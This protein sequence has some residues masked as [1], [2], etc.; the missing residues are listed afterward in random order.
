I[1]HN[2]RPGSSTAL[3]EGHGGIVGIGTSTFLQQ[4][5]STVGTRLILLTAMLIGMLLVADD[6]VLRTPGVVAATY[7]HVKQHAPAMKINFRFP[8][9]PKLPSLPKF[10][11]KDSVKPAT[12]R[13]V[14]DD[15]DEP[16]KQPV[17]LKT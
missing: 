6:L 14:A 10:V 2:V 11:T 15:D 17:T 3:P 12:R 5:F 16:I 13:P 1:L 8:E 4:H 9:L 7:A